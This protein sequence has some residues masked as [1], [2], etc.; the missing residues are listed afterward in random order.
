MVVSLAVSQ[1]GLSYF[2]MWSQVNFTFVPCSVYLLQAT[3]GPQLPSSSLFQDPL[4]PLIGGS[5][6]L[7]FSLVSVLCSPPH[8]VYV[9]P[10]FPCLPPV[11]ALFWIGAYQQA[12]ALLLVLSCY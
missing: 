3:P 11:L 8:F 6:S 12:I 4:P 9:V 7:A 10:H 5:M 1:T 2:C